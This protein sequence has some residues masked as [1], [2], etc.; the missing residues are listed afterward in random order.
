MPNQNGETSVYR[1]SGI[2]DTEIFEIGKRFVA[3][4]NDKPL[5]GRTDIVVS[6]V[7]EQKLSVN[8][9][10]TPHHRH[11]NICG[12][13]DEKSEKRLIAIELENHAKPH[14]IDNS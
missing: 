3:S 6:K 1:I 4:V 14:L 7:I 5:L 8:P 12:W 13:P 9:D 10:P 2:S 11:A